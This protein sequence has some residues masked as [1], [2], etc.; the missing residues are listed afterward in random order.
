MNPL[1]QN[2]LVHEQDITS[3]FSVEEQ[4]KEYKANF[5]NSLPWKLLNSI[6]FLTFSNVNSNCSNL[7][8]NLKKQVKKHS[9][10]KNC[11]DLSLF[12][13]IAYPP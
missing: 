8:R 12:D 7:L 2:N 5:L 11:S 10:T 4:R 9:V 1:S 6:P 13:Q 3:V